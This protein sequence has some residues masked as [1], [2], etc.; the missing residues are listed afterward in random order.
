MKKIFT[1]KNIILG[2][3]FIIFDIIIYLI[4]GLKLLIYE[5]F[6]DKISGPYWS[7]ESMTISEKIAYIG[8][9]A[10]WVLN[11]L[12]VIFIGYKIFK[13]FQKSTIKQIHN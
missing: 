2:V 4:I 1:I 10:W 3:L 12:L 6:Y 9:C 7:L 11:I 13:T 8:F 5:D